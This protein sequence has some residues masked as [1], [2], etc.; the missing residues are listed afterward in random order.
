M[1]ALL[2]DTLKTEAS[3]FVGCVSSAIDLQS[4]M[5]DVEGDSGT[6][7]ESKSGEAEGDEE[8]YNAIQKVNR[9]LLKM[10]PLVAK[11]PPAAFE[12]HIKAIRAFQKKT[13]DRANAL[14]VA[15]LDKGNKTVQEQYDKALQAIDED[16]KLQAWLQGLR[17]V[18]KTWPKLKKHYQQTFI[19]YD[20]KPIDT[21]I[22]ALVKEPQPLVLQYNSRNV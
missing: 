4:A 20:P 12:S 5:S 3:H 2:P 7:P 1:S 11:K 15:M 17:D 19:D 6:G 18:S 14:V 9:E 10:K 16:Q 13:Q 22:A 8:Q 21:M